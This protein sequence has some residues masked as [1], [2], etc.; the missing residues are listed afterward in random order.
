MHSDFQNYQKKK[1]ELKINFDFCFASP[2]QLT[3]WS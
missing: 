3:Q 2:E 1:I